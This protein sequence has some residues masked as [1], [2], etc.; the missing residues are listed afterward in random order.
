[1]LNSCQKIRYCLSIKHHCDPILNVTS[2]FLDDY[3]IQTVAVGGTGGLAT[4]G[5]V[6]VAGAAGGAASVVA[7]GIAGAE[8]A[9]VVGAC[10]GGT[11]LG[12]VTFGVGTAMKIEI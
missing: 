6:S 1:M 11:S 7:G 12:C 9:G 4:V 5:G 10:D 2:Y 3:Y 8:V